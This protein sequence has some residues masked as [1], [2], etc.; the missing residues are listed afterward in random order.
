MFQGDRD[1]CLCF[2]TVRILFSSE[3]RSSVREGGKLLGSVSQAH[4]M[5]QNS[6]FQTIHFAGILLFNYDVN[7]TQLQAEEHQQTLPEDRFR[8]QRFLNPKICSLDMKY[9]KNTWVWGPIRKLLP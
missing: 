7:E 3:D 6:T 9:E 1:A 2:P 4:V 5:H 8:K